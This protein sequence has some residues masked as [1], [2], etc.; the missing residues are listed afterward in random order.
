MR[1][2]L[3]GSELRDASMRK[4]PSGILTT[5]FDGMIVDVNGLITISIRAY[6]S[7]ATEPFV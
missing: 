7:K 5:I 6:K 3:R 4:Y 2:F 1:L